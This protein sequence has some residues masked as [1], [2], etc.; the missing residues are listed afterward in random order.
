MKAVQDQRK[1]PRICLL[2]ESP[3]CTIASEQISKTNR[4]RLFVAEK[5]M[6]RDALLRHFFYFL[7]RQYYAKNRKMYDVARGLVTLLHG[8]ELLLPVDNQSVVCYLK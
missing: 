1:K 2:C 6:K 3:K 8:K 5:L 4:I 7:L